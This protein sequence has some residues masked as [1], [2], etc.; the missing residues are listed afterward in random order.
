MSAVLELDGTTHIV[1][2]GMYDDEKE[3]CFVWVFRNGRRF[4]IDVSGGDVRGTPFYDIWR[5]L[6]EE[7]DPKSP[8]GRNWVER[9]HTLASCVITASLQKLRKLAPE[10]NHWTTLSDYLHTPSYRLQV[11]KQDGAENGVGAEVTKGPEDAPAY[12]FT[13]YDIDMFEGLPKD[14]SRVDSHQLVVLNHDTNWRVPPHQVK[15]SGGQVFRFKGCEKPTRTSET[16]ELRCRSRDSIKCSL[17]L[18][19]SMQKLGLE[20]VPGLPAVTGIV[21]DIPVDQE[22][23][24]EKSYPKK[25]VAGILTSWTGSDTIRDLVRNA[26]ASDADDLLNRSAS[27]QIRVE[28]ALNRLHAVGLSFC[29]S[30]G[31]TRISEHDIYIDEKDEAWLTTGISFVSEPRSGDDHQACIAADLKAV[32]ELF[33]HWFRTELAKKKRT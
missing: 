17:R 22:P 2:Y 32:R 11:V 30:D 15:T 12:E 13:P 23:A 16:G 31:R 6:I 24:P 25:L 14:V 27:W 26:E 4:I 5:P 19:E 9:W 7:V 8:A 21:L 28:D 18:H 20:P 33:N 1:R 10:Q 3:K 29:G